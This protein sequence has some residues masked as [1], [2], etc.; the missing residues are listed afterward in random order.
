MIPMPVYPQDIYREIDR[1][2]LDRTA[3][4]K[5]SQPLLGIAK[6]AARTLKERSVK[7]KRKRIADSGQ[8]ISDGRPISP[9]DDAPS[10]FPKTISRSCLLE[11]VTEGQ[12]PFGRSDVGS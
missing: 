7:R 2:W 8:L 3:R 1:K 4:A 6:V 10:T 5:P 9:T 12:K 11:N